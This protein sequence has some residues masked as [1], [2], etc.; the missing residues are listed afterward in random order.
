MTPISSK[1][2]DGGSAISIYSSNQHIDGG[3]A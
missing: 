2:I 1:N 3:N